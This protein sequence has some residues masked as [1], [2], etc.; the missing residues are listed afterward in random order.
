MSTSRDVLKFGAAAAVTGMVATEFQWATGTPLDVE[1]RPSLF[2]PENVLLPGSPD[3]TVTLPIDGKPREVQPLSFVASLPAPFDADVYVWGYYVPSVIGVESVAI[4]SDP[5]TGDPDIDGDSE[6]LSLTPVLRHRIVIDEGIYRNAPAVEPGAA[7][8]A[9]R[10]AARDAAAGPARPTVRLADPVPGSA[11]G[12][13][14]PDVSR[15]MILVEIEKGAGLVQPVLVNTTSWDGLGDGR[16]AA[17]SLSAACGEYDVDRDAPRRA[18]PPEIW[19]SCNL[20]EATQHIHLVE[21]SFVRRH[22]LG[23][24][25]YSALHDLLWP[26]VPYPRPV[27]DAGVLAAR[28]M[29]LRPE[30][31][32]SGSAPG[33]PAD[34]RYILPSPAALG[35][36]GG[37]PLQRLGVPFGFDDPRGMDDG[38]TG[39][40]GPPVTLSGLGPVE[41]P[42]YV[43]HCL[44]V[45]RHYDETGCPHRFFTSPP[46]VS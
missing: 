25:T 46:T 2:G 21:F 14:T 32:V 12:G 45:S 3:T 28:G 18:V 20:V 39:E 19:E 17:A 41:G 42:G 38:S 7:R 36:P 22:R 5:P 11:S 8:P 24:G 13:L 9:T 44:T 43:W 30:V 34:D 15:R 27:T 4:E 33:R 29:G 10:R 1:G 6:R 31:Y 26:G 40:A 16:P 35:V 37:G 23:A